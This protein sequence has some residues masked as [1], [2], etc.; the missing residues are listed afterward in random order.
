MVVLVVRGYG[1]GRVLT[2][3][4]HY[5]QYTKAP[6]G[7]RDK[8][9]FIG[10]PRRPRDNSFW[11]ATVFSTCLNCFEAI[12]DDNRADKKDDSSVT[13]W[14]RSGRLERNKILGEMS[15][16]LTYSSQGPSDSFIKVPCIDIAPKLDWL[17]NDN[18]WTCTYWWNVHVHTQSRQMFTTCLLVI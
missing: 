12:Q 5:G 3:C 18:I 6:E 8:G 1:E 7:G 10:R 9:T 16:L 15:A 2:L 13:I 4:R 17:S 11:S 14:S